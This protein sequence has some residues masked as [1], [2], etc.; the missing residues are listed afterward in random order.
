MGRYNN[1]SNEDARK[2]SSFYYLLVAL[3][4]FVIL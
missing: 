2:D 3:E 4:L 1:V